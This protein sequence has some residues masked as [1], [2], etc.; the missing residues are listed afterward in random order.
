LHDRE[1]NVYLRH[2]EQNLYLAYDQKSRTDVL[3]K[4][5]NWKATV[6]GKDGNFERDDHFRVSLFNPKGH[7]VATFAVT[8]GGG[9]YDAL[10]D[11]GRDGTLRDKRSP[12][13]AEAVTFDVP[14]QAKAKADA[15]GF[16]AEMVIPWQSL[17]DAGISREG[18]MVECVRKSRWGGAR[19]ASL[20]KLLENGVE[21]QAL[22]QPPAARKFTLRLHFAELDDVAPGERVFDVLVQGQT[23]LKGVDVV[24]EAGGRYRALV[25][26]VRDIVADR[27]MEIR[28]VPRGGVVNERTAPILN[29]LEFH[30]Q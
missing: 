17:A 9:T 28:L 22:N 8:A 24:R 7:R 5:I 30:S 21:V 23:V 16:R 25:K 15:E 10:L 13:P 29:A 11:L 12:I 26:E 3:G 2:D 4:T 20:L 6:R 1:A 14:W 18:L 19:D 27:A